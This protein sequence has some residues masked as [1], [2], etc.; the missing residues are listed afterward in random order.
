VVGD[1]PVES[2]VSTGVLLPQ[3]DRVLVRAFARDEVVFTK[4]FLVLGM[5]ER[6]EQ[7]SLGDFARS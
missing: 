2:E 3:P 4:Q 5:L 6:R 1:V 7:W